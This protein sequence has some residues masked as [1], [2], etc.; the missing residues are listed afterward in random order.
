VT[1]IINKLKSFKGDPNFGQ[2]AESIARD[3]AQIVR[4]LSILGV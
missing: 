4:K 1:S 2:R 3:F